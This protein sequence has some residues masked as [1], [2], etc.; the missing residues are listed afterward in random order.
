MFNDPTFPPAFPSLTIPSLTPDLPDPVVGRG[1]GED[2]EASA[3]SFILPIFRG[4][5]LPQKDHCCL[6]E[7]HWQKFNLL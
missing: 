1:L 3:V 5:T 6:A 4:K 7:Y 2:S